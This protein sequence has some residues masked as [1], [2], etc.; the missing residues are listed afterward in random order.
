MLVCDGFMWLTLMTNKGYFQGRAH[1]V[2]PLS[3]HLLVVDG[4]L[5][6]SED[7]FPTRV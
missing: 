4:H 5:R 7:Q 2:P 1:K 6:M 3:R